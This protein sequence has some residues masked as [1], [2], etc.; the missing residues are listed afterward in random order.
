MPC[1]F[2][3]IDNDVSFTLVLDDFGIKFSSLAGAK[4][5]IATLQAFYSLKV[6][7]TGSQYLGMSIKLDR[8]NGTLSLSMPGYI[9]KVSQRFKSP[10]QAASPGVYVLPVYGARVQYVSATAT[11]EPPLTAAEATEVRG[12]VGLILS[13]AR[14]IDPTILPAVTAIA[15]EQAALVPHDPCLKSIGS[16]PT[17]PLTLTTIS[18]RLLR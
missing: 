12:K 9:A 14:A 1:L 4:L 10:K 11:D 7:W 3:H 8:I 2:R 16:S 18:T 17:A 15:S 6:D 5:L 13:Y